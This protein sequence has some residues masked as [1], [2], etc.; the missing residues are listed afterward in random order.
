M[1]QKGAKSIVLVSRS[2][3]ISDKVAEVIAEAKTA[4]ASVVLHRCDVSS[5]QDVDRMVAEIG[6]QL[7]PVRGVIHSAM[8]LDDVLFEKM[9]F[10]QWAKVVES[11]VAGCWNIHTA[12]SG[13]KLDFFIALS[14]VAGI[15]GNHGQA[16]Y[17]AANTFLDAF[18]QFRRRLG[19]AAT[20][21]DLAAVSDT[22]YLA[23]NAER[24]KEVMAQIG[25]E[26]ISEKEILALVA[27]A[28][29]GKAEATAT[30]Q[31]IT[32]L[33]LPANP[34]SLFW[35]SDAKFA[36]LCER[37]AAD[38]AAAGDGGATSAVSPSAAL[39]KAGSYGEAHSVVIEALLDKTASVLM[40]PREELDPTKDTVTYGLDSLVSIEIRNWI[41]R[42]LG[43]S[44]Q[45][46]DLLSSGSFVSLAETVL[47][48]SEFVSFEK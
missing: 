30:S 43:A 35:A 29:T 2:D 33:K 38:Q 16:A 41:T 40:L 12:L 5:S 44:L 25:G 21:L 13:A 32:G 34:T 11:K 20:T 42:E 45:I 36:P 27:A 10:G 6:A 15:I 14:S 17:A 19:L 48:K 26:A 7:P 31:V 39:K 28:I 4:G 22:G 3:K 23:E 8:V 37:A 1:V 47:K 9:Q 24:Q 18:V 46:L